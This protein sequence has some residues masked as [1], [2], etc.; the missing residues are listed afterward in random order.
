L[1]NEQ[2]FTIERSTPLFRK[3]QNPD[4]RVKRFGGIQGVQSNSKKK[5]LVA[6]EQKRW[7]L[8]KARNR[9]RKELT[10]FDQDQIDF[11]DEILGQ[12]Q[13]GAYLLSS[14]LGRTCC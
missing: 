9:L 12:S 3:S 5:T 6:G 10:G 14:G 7:D 4:C 1:I 8:A 13:H 2:R 11:I